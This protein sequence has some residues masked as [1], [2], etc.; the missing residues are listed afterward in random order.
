MAE[1]KFIPMNALVEEGKDAPEGTV[2]VKCSCC[3]REF[4]VNGEDAA[5]SLF[6]GVHVCE[7]CKPAYEQ[8]QAQ[9]NVNE[10]KTNDAAET[11]S[12][13]LGK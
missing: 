2:K 6:N 10:M 8:Q 11:I 13:A 7:E 9:A 1:V 5:S 12:T 4:A 3:G